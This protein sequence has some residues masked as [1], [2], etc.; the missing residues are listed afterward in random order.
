MGFFSNLQ[1][2]TESKPTF[3][4]E[5]QAL[6]TPEKN[7]C[8]AISEDEIVKSDMFQECLNSLKKVYE[9][10]S[11]V[12]VK[13][14]HLMVHVQCPYDDPYLIVLEY[15]GYDLWT[16]N[17]KKYKEETSWEEREKALNEFRKDLFGQ[18]A[19]QVKEL[20][21]MEHIA[22]HLIKVEDMEKWESD[23]I[24][25]YDFM[26]S[27]IPKWGSPRDIRNLYKQKLKER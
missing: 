15:K 2:K 17:L 3:K 23:F 7:N 14:L 16:E 9:W 22:D 21:N 26:I 11:L 24:L 8:P 13:D 19:E 20:V 5:E 27:Y 10:M 1:K 18:N 12:D 25:R 4:K 6:P